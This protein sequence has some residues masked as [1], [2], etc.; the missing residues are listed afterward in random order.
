[1]A[2]RTDRGAEPHQQDHAPQAGQTRPDLRTRPCFMAPFASPSSDG[3]PNA[4]SSAPKKP[5][6]QRSVEEEGAHYRLQV[7][8]PIPDVA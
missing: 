7:R 3:T 8:E 1:V 4:P 5:P 2:D 6:L